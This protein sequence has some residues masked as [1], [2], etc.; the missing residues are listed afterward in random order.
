[1]DKINLLKIYTKL[2]KKPDIK[3][4]FIFSLWF[5]PHQRYVHLLEEWLI[6][7]LQ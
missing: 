3:K 1:M 6:M 2:A 4:I 5:N 7:K